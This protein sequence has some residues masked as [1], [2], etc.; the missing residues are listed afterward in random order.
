MGTLAIDQ[1]NI[2]IKDKALEGVVNTLNRVLSDAH[3][4]YVKTRN[5]HWNVTGMQFHSLHVLLEQ[6]YTQLAT[7]IDEIAEHV[8]SRGGRALGTMAEFLQHA[9]L[10]EHVEYPDARGMIKELLHDHEEVIRFLRESIDRCDDE[11]KDVTTSDFLTGLARDHE[12][13]AWMLRAHLEGK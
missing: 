4:L 9:Q 3:V 2:G 6:Q 5:Y 8:R 12:K 7:A 13:M 10:K 1:I 11:F